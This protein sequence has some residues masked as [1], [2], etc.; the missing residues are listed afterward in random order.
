VTITSGPDETT[1]EHDAE[2]AFEVVDLVGSGRLGPEAAASVMCSLDGQPAE[3]C[4]S[5]VRYEDLELG[6]HEV[7]IIATDGDGGE[8]S[9]RYE[10]AVVAGESLERTDPTASPSGA[11]RLASAVSPTNV[12]RAVLSFTGAHITRMAILGLMLIVVGVG[13]GTAANVAR[14]RSD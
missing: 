7:L 9:A 5:P 4:T 8:G 6:S 2:I 1:T 14:R 12:Q 11:E 13:L 3:P 10:W